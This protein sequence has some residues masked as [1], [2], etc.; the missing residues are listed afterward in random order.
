MLAHE[1]G[2]VV[3]RHGAQ[4]IAKQRLTQG[5]TGA[6]VL[7]TYDPRSGRGQQS[8]AM[9][10]TIGSLI[11]MKYGRED[12]HESDVWGVLILTQAEYDPHALIGV[13]EVLAAAAKGPRPPEFMSTH[14][15]SENRI[16]RIKE[17]I[18]KAL[19]DGVPQHF[20]R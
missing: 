19:P 8:A 5:L 15:S 11:N 9:A 6:A 10:A 12:E 16:E 7:A 1:I 3:E 18:V 14:P 20:K 17:A 4:R 13:M 2:H